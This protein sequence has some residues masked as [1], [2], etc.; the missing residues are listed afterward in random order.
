MS[1]AL[2]RDVRNP[3]SAGASEW[4][5]GRSKVGPETELFFRT[6]RVTG[7]LSNTEAANNIPGDLLVAAA[8]EAGGGRLGVA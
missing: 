8:V 7:R 4:R 6:A 3:E 1:E 5:K 2:P